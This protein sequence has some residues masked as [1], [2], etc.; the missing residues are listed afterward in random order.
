[1][2]KY[3]WKEINYPSKIE[4]WKMLQKNNLTNALNILYIKEL[5]VCPAYISKI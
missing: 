2:N 4:D 1:M 3:N 5:E